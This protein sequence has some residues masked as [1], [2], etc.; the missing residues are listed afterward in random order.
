M[1]AVMGKG[2]LQGVQDLHVGACDHRQAGGE[3]H[4]T[5]CSLHRRR[6]PGSEGAGDLKELELEL[7]LTLPGS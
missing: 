1:W 3:G 7:E 4:I 6:N 2:N 5:H